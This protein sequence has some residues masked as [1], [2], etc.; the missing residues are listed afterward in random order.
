MAKR[1]KG[2]RHQ[3]QTP[4]GNLSDVESFAAYL[5][6]YIEALGI[7]H[8]T[9]ATLYNN[10]RYLR[11]FIRWGED[12]ALTRPNEITKPIIERYQRHLYYYRKQD[13][14]PLS[15]NSQRCHLTPLKGFFKWLTR[16]NHIL[17]NPASEIELPKLQ[18]RL[19]KYV[20]T[21]T[22]VETIMNQPDTSDPYGV[23]DRAMLETLYST[24]IRR[25][26][27]VNLKTEDIDKDRG[28]LIIREGKGRKDRM[29]PVGDTAMKWLTQ[30]QEWV[31]PDLATPPDDY[32]LFLTKY[33]KGFNISWLSTLVGSYI[34][35]ADIGKSGG[36]HLFRHTMATLMLE[37]GADIRFIQAMLGHAE[38]STT[39]IYTQVAMRQLK[40]VHNATHP[41]NQTQTKPNKEEENTARKALI[42][43]LDAETEDET[44]H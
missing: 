2:E 28:C 12:R 22:E 38:L 30:Y 8:C 16:N 14:E 44:K 13:G 33:G 11:H 35:A 41:A 24:G 10:E 39:Q 42:D 27:I 29:L 15:I 17:Y 4:I 37:N 9:E 34:K 3:F 40:A 19:P 7:K 5:A 1:R 43:T 20:L 6:R 18:R 31:R 25:A 23:R 26:E 32:T 21:Q 36:C